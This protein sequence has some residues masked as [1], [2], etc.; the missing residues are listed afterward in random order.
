MALTKFVEI[1][2]L[3]SVKSGM[4][5]FYTPQSSDETILV[6]VAPNTVDDMF[7]HRH[8]T[9][10]L[11][12]V[13]G[14]MVLVVL[15]NREYRYIPMSDRNPVVVTIPPMVPHAAINLDSEPCM[16]INAVNYHGQSDAREYQP[17]T[18]PFAYDLAEAERLSNTQL[19]LLAS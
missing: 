2:E 10:R 12:A 17:I 7:V 11:I 16:L 4:V 8:Q 5:E 3:D 14:S 13:R 18:P 6:R 19:Q 1:R 15:Q 9:D